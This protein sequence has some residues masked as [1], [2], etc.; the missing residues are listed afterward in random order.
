MCEEKKRKEGKRQRQK[1]PKKGGGRETGRLNKN[2]RGKQKGGK[3]VTL[4][5]AATNPPPLA[6][7]GAGLAFPNRK[8]KG[9]REGVHEVLAAIMSLPPSFPPPLLCPP[10]SAVFNSHFVL[11]SSS[12]FNP[13]IACRPSNAIEP[14]T[15]SSFFPSLHYLH[16]PSQT[17][18]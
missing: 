16:T 2:K 14:S 7:G 5:A 6:C 13:E 11:V 9:R 12:H 10:S 17:Q 3:Q 8:D 15:F 1:R 18:P 4:C